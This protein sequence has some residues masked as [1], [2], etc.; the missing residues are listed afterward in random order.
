MNFIL[1]L[2]RWQS[3]I[4]ADEVVGVIPNNKKIYKKT[5]DIAWPSALESVFIALI[6][7][8]DMMMVGFLGKEAISAVGIATQPKFIVLAPIMALNVG[9]TVLV[10]RRKGEDKQADA[11]GYLRT[12][13]VISLAAS[14]ILTLSGW[15]FARPFLLF[16]GASL[17]YIELGV[18]YFRIV[19]VGTFFYAIGLTLTAAQRGAGNTRIS[20]YTNLAANLVNLVFNALLINGLFFFPRLEVVGAAIAT[21]IGNFVSFGMAVYSVSHKQRYLYLNPRESWRL[22]PQYLKDI[23]NI[24]SSSF[25]EQVFLRVGFFMYAKAVAT[26]GTIAFAAH[27]ICMNIMTIS[28]AFGDGLQ[29]ANTSLV[30]QSL[31][32]RRPDMAKIYTKVAQRL[33]MILAFCLGLSCFIF[34]DQILSLFTSDPAVIAMGEIP[35]SILAV[36][37]LF[38]VPQVIIVG[39]LRGAGDVKFVALLMLVSVT[40]IRPG[41]AWLLCYPLEFGLLGAWIALFFDQITRNSISVLRFRKGE[42]SRIVI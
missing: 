2:F 40:I 21:A 31:G 12:A 9:V 27:Q 41:L 35:M 3:M 28:F 20:M 34:R 39:A 10:S 13:V 22:K 17:D 4:K 29:I 14:F 42:W 5:F 38:Q 33:G 11:N 1:K 36:T 25:V 26:L 6:G 19:M 32:A 7:A 23:W 15:L 24:S 18:S 16:A 30:G 37:I 8:V